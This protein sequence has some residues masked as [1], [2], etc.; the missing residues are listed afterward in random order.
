MHKYFFHESFE[1]L[2]HEI[3]VGFEKIQDGGSSTELFATS[4]LPDQPK[5]CRSMTIM[6]FQNRHFFLLL[7][8]AESAQVG[9]SRFRKPQVVPL[10]RVA[11]SKLTN[12][13]SRSAVIN[14]C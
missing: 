8:L 1:I 13:T 4:L 12:R 11:Y 2:A 14:L 7:A 10:I 6:I 5:P 9:L 3:D